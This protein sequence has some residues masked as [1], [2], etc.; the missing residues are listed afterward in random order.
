[1]MAQWLTMAILLMAILPLLAA[2]GL[3]QK[4]DAIE[5]SVDSVDSL[6]QAL[7]EAEQPTTLHLKGSFSISQPVHLGAQI[8]LIGSGDALIKCT[9]GNKRAFNMPMCVG[10]ALHPLHHPGEA[11]WQHDWCP[12]AFVRPLTPPVRPASPP[13]LLFPLPHVSCG[14]TSWWALG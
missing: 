6:V 1:M 5:R 2:D 7:K 8:S 9:N 13:I 14:L 4:K 12:G 10:V 11:P 3:L